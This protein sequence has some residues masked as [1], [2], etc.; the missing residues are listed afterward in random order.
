MYFRNKNNKL[1]LENIRRELKV[2][3]LFRKK[4]E[5]TLGREGDG[6]SQYVNCQDY[7]EPK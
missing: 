4:R 7:H 6:R 2:I 1:H 3:G 5:K